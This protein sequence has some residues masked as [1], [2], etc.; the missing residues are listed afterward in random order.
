VL[1]EQAPPK[2]EERT[3]AEEAAPRSKPPQLTDTNLQESQ[4]GLAKIEEIVTKLMVV[5]CGMR[6]KLL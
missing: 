3:G 6:R 2:V 1:K 4:V 5:N